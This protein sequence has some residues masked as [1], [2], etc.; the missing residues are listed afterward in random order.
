MME[1]TV[2]NGSYSVI[3]GFSTVFQNL[4]TLC[5]YLS[6]SQKYSKFC[7]TTEKRQTDRK[8]TSV[9]SVV[10]NYNFSFLIS[11]LNFLLQT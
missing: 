5:V 7:H 8:I 2:Q 9:C 3:L 1:V 10:L 4:R 11:V 6:P